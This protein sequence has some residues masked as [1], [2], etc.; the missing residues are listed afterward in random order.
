[1]VTIESITILLGEREYTVFE[2][3]RLRS[4]PWKERFMAEVNPLFA[5]IGSAK[6]ME[7]RGPE[8]V[9]ALLPVFESLF[10][11]GFDTVFELLLA[12]APELEADREYIE[13]SATDKQVF[14]GFLGV[15]RLADPFGMVDIARLMIGRRMMQIPSKSPLVNGA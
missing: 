7:I 12:Y 15:V 13:S 9:L 3:P 2:A 4:K 14:A 10:T 6:E 5:R 1:M 8:D 11:S